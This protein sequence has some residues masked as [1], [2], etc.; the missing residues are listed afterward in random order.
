MA[1]KFDKKEQP[2]APGNKRSY[3]AI[4]GDLRDDIGLLAAWSGKTM[5]QVG[6]EL[7]EQAVEEVIHKVPK[8][9]TGSARREYTRR[10]KK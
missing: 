6:Y 10:E 7:L 5:Q 4:Y 1:I 3:I 8:N 2:P 9:Y